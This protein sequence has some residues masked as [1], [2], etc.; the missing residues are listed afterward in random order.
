MHNNFCAKLLTKAGTSSTELFVLYYVPP[1]TQ[2]NVPPFVVKQ[3]L[4]DIWDVMLCILNFVIHIYISI[5]NSCPI[6]VERKQNK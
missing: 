1:S 5:D 6:H 3:L 2:K 4:A